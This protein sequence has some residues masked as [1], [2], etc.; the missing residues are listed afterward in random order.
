M[1]SR[2]LATTA[3]YAALA[4]A[5]A[6]AFAEPVSASILVGAMLS[7]GAA[8]ASTTAALAL[9]AGFKAV[10]YTHLRAHET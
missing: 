10:S 1:R 2:L 4:I 3:L 9:A 5:P 6:S 8:A 7:G